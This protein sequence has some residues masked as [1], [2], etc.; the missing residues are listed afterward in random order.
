MLMLIYECSQTLIA[1][2]LSRAISGVIR[3][4]LEDA[5]SS[6][7]NMSKLLPKRLMRQHPEWFCCV[8]LN[9]QC[10][11]ETKEQVKRQTF[12]ECITFYRTV[13]EN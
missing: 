2:I 11:A 6:L 4:Q 12:N 1:T 5:N 10:Y 8:L 3:V 7:W 13:Y 9:D